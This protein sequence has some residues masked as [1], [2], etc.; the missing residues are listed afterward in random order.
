MGPL[1]RHYRTG[2]T[3]QAAQTQLSAQMVAGYA[4]AEEK[5]NA[6][7]DGVHTKEHRYLDAYSEVRKRIGNARTQEGRLCWEKSL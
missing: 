3:S 4:D 7:L 1:N 2:R 5:T 6:F